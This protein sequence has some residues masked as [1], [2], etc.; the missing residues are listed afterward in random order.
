MSATPTSTTATSLHALAT[1]IQSIPDPRSK[2]GVSHPFAGL[3]A[4]VLLGLTAR[5]IYMSHIVEWAKLHWQELKEPLGFDSEKP[6]SDTTI[7]RALAKLK[8]KDFQ[9][10]MTA[11]SG[12]LGRLP[13][14][15]S[16]RTVRAHTSAYGSSK[17]CFATW[18][19]FTSFS[20]E[21]TV[22]NLWNRQ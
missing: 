16:H 1:A 8:L 22:N 7:S 4:L 2:Q 3:L 18:F 20:F 9:Q 17:L 14:Q 5:Q 10:A 6:P 13:S 12:G 11:L 19:S 21:N 15:D